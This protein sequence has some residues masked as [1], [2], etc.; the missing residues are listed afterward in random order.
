[1]R[2]EYAANLA[3]QSQPR[4]QPVARQPVRRQPNRSFFGFIVAMFASAL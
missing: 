1:M 4:Q 3:L 2:S